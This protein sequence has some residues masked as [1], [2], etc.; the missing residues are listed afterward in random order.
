MKL[1]VEADA[2][3]IHREEAWEHWRALKKIGLTSQEVDVHLPNLRD[4][5]RRG[6]LRPKDFGA[7]EEEFDKVVK[8]AKAIQTE[9]WKHQ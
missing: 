1:D 2:R 6:G 5:M 4:V 9:A 7:D 8:Y 3:R